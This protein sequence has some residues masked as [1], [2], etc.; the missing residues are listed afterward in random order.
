MYLVST[1][2]FIW[3]V[4]EYCLQL[5][6]SAIVFFFNLSLS[7]SLAQVPNSNHIY[8]YAYLVVILIGLLIF[9]FHSFTEVHEALKSLL[10]YHGWTG[11]WKGLGPTLLRDVPFSGTSYHYVHFSFYLY[12][13]WQIKWFKAWWFF[14]IN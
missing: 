13:S 2:S 3:V 14:F 8:L 5:S 11:L 4:L 1:T 7:F 10:R 12:F 9:L 6:D